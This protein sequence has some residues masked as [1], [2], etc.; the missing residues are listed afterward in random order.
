MDRATLTLN[1]GTLAAGA[2]RRHD[3]GPLQAGNGPHTIAP[4]AGLSAAQYGLL[5]LYGGLTTNANTTLAFNL[6]APLSSGTYNGDLIDMGGSPL[7]VK[8]GAITFGANPTAAGDYRLFENLGLTSSATTFSLP[9]PA[10]SVAWTGTSSTAGWNSNHWSSS[11]EAY[12]LS[13]SVDPGYLNL[14]VASTTSNSGPSSNSTVSF[15]GTP[16]A[17][18]TVTLDGN[19]SVAALV[20]NTAGSNG[21]TLSRGTGGV[22]TLGT[23]SGAAVAVNAGSQ[24][25]NAPVVLAN[26]LVVT[27]SGTLAFGV[28]SSIGDN[29]SQYSLL[30]DG[31]GGTLVLS[32]SNAYT[33]GTFVNAGILNA[34][35]AS[36]LPPGESLTVGA[37]G[38]FVFG[39]PLAGGAIIP[40]SDAA[41][42]P[43]SVPEPGTFALLAC[44]AAVIALGAVAAAEEIRRGKK[45]QFKLRGC[46]AR[47]N[48]GDT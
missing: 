23:A 9:T 8:G 4:G 5:S 41:A 47:G 43:A 22:L 15:A 42:G 21:Y 11:T 37:G 17:P 45:T 26:D 1:G 25:I 34:T 7:T 10:S 18:V 14:V 20:F 3:R 32:G 28:S 2:G 12:T 13:T 38:T 27:G 44:G 19:Q 24:A 36:A 39:S 46:G 48:S 29:G 35:A 6:G 31:E 40:S 30:M 16:A 33:G